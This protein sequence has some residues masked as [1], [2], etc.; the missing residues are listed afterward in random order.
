VVTGDAR[1]GATLT[2]S[3]ATPAARGTKYLFQWQTQKKVIVKKKTVTRWVAIAGAGAA[4]FTPSPALTGASVRACVKARAKG[5]SPAWKC[6]GAKVVAAAISGEG[7]PLSGTPAGAPGEISPGAAPAP[8]PLNAARTPAFATPTPTATG[9]TVQISNYD[10]LWTWGASATSSGSAAVSNTGLVTVTGVAPSTSS[11]V[12]V[13]TTRT[14]YVDGSASTSATSLDPLSISYFSGRF[15]TGSA[16]PLLPATVTGGS[17]TKRFEVSAGTLPDGI[18]LDQGTGTFTGP[19]AS[20]WNFRAIQ[21]AAGNRHTCALTASGGVKCWGYGTEGQLGNGL[22]PPV[23]STPV[24]V[25]ATGQ[26]PGGTALSDVTQIAAGLSH[27]CALTTSGGLKCWGFAVNGQ[28]GNGATTPST[29]STPVD[30]CVTATTPGTCDGAPLGGVAQIAAGGNHTCAITTSGGVK[31][32][33]RGVSD[34]LGDGATSNQSTPVDVLATGQGPGGTPLSYVTQIAA[35]V[36]HTCA[37]TTSGG[38]KCWGAG[39]NGQLGNGATP[40]TQSTPVDVVATGGSGT[41]SDITQITAGHYHTCA[42]TTSGGVKCWGLGDSGQL[43]NGDVPTT[44]STPV[45]VCV[46][47]TAPGTCDGTPLRGVTQI[48]AGGAHT[49][50]LTTTG[51]VKCWG[52][53]LH[54]RL[55]NGAPHTEVTPVDVVATGQSQNGT[56]L[57]GITQIAAGSGHTCALTTSGG[58]KCWGYGAEGQLG[59]GAGSSQS[60]PVDVTGS[61]P[62]VGFPA[63]LTVTATDDTGSTTTSVNLTEVSKPWFSYPNVLFTNGLDHEQLAPVARGGSGTKEFS[64]SGTLPGGVTFNQAT[65]TFTGPAAGWNFKATQVAAGRNHTCALTT[66]QGVKCWGNGAYGQLGNGTLTDTQSTPVDVCVSVLTPGACAGTPLRGVSQIAAGDSHTCALTT[67]QGV[68]CWGYGGDL[69]DGGV[70]DQ[71]TPVNVV[72]TGEG[73]G[74]AALSGITQIAT[75]GTDTCAL[76]TSGGVK[77]WGVGASG[78]L[79]DGDTSER[80]TPVDVCVTVV[81]PG[82]CNGTPLR[83]VTQIAAGTFHTCVLTGSGGVK[84]WGSGTSGELGN[85]SA[86]NQSTP[87]DVVATGEGPGGAALADV[88]RITAGNDH[89]C[90][91]TLSGGV[92]CWGYGGGLGNGATSGTQSTPVDVVATGEGLGGTA[93]SGITQIAAGQLHTCALTTSGGVKCWGY[94]AHGELGSGVTPLAQRTPVDVVATGQSQNGTA[95]SGISQIAAGSFHACA[96]TTSQGV[97]CWGDGGDGQLGND[98]TPNP[99]STPVDVT[100][101]GPLVGYPAVLSVTV[102]DDIGSWTLGRVV[103]GI[104]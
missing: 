96:V 18:T 50:V 33:G 38:V 66:S 87:V 99:Q 85:G 5:A 27:T 80:L 86:S 101:S 83:D 55:G 43:G 84:C 63:A 45:D 100:G 57:S 23:P 41:L 12:T 40:T 9:F 71:S 61:G 24:D 77:C 104:K 26:G 53:G 51:G 1:V 8:A 76:T 39:S 78:Q 14:G 92:K 2:A 4:T 7:G 54:G 62:V 13:T 70:T 102:T 89:T 94:N 42:L 74:G 79:G 36:S 69:G 3:V 68:K 34:Q 75:G 60:A 21:I 97:K 6:S 20:A 59:N 58:V 29:Q 65:G 82:I 11:R 32:W 91:L 17:G 90:A 47:A 19:A 93:L 56:P 10:A 81:T 52:E 73:P 30:V 48:A 72:A 46:T 44:Q 103:V 88:S 49:C 31:C 16:S 35:G 64:V 98:A 37:L 95:L 15:I 22:T 25:V 28:L 67:S